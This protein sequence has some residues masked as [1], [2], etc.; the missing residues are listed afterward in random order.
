MQEKEVELRRRYQAIQEEIDE[1]KE[2]EEGEEEEDGLMGS[3]NGIGASREKLEIEE[4]KKQ[5]LVSEKEK[6]ELLERAEGAE[7]RLSEE[8]E[9]AA[10]QQ[11]KLRNEV[12]TFIRWKAAVCTKL[13]AHRTFIMQTLKVYWEK[14]NAEKENLLL[15]VAE[16]TVTLIKLAALAADQ[17]VYTVRLLNEIKALQ[18]DIHN[19]RCELEESRQNI[20]QLQKEKLK[21]E[22][23]LQVSR[24]QVSKLE[25][26]EK[27][28]SYEIGKLKEEN[29]RLTK[30][31]ESTNKRHK[32]EIDQLEET[33]KL[34]LAK[35]ASDHT[36]EV[37]R[38]ETLVQQIEA[39]TSKAME[40][41]MEVREKQHTTTIEAL[42][43]AKN[44][45]IK[46]KEAQGNTLRELQKIV[47]KLQREGCTKPLN[48]APPSPLSP[49]SPLQSGLPDSRG[50]LTVC[51][52][53]R[54]TPKL[55]MSSIQNEDSVVL[56]L[57]KRAQQWDDTWNRKKD[58]FL[59]ETKD[60][61][62]TLSEVYVL[63]SDT[64]KK[65]NTYA[66]F[67]KRAL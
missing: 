27:Q 62:A 7:E 40:K 58:R 38:L 26:L 59:K 56:R 8:R 57:Y 39:K 21:L 44:K 6:E 29:K 20:E 47:K 35:V 23:D 14:L 34:K 45:L 30:T 55:V 17:E 66:D 16:M 9:Q 24:N 43:T 67:V 49:L 25:E 64:G 46:E 1:E 63:D 18:Q 60:H 65:V 52:E 5:Y 15:Q 13:R 53:P 11:Q 28:R 61:L 10:E 36:Q 32:K 22:L 4:L 12:G 19:F 48:Q 33:F 42:E 54:C 37:N 50:K 2:E 51:T 3:I 41:L 31:V